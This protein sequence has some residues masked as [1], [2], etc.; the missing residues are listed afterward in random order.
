M[1]LSELLKK[2]GYIGNISDRNITDITCNSREAT[3][4]SVFVCIK[5]FVTDGHIYAQKAYECGCRA[6]VAEQKLEGIPEDADILYIDDA[7]RALALLSRTLYGDPS[8]ELTVIG[9]TGTKG[10]TTTALIIKQLLDASDVPTGYIGSNGVSY[11]KYKFD[12][13]NTTPESYKLQKY[14]REMLNA[15]MKAVVIEVSSQALALGRVLGIHFD[16]A[17]FTNLSSDHIGPHEH[18][19]FEEYFNA[20]KRLFDEYEPKT[21][22]ANADDPNTDAILT[23]CKAEIIYY[24]T[25]NI[26]DISAKKI[27]LYR[28]ES[29]LGTSFDCINGGNSVHCL[30]PIPGEFNVYNALA[31]LATVQALGISPTKASEALPNIKTEGRFEVIPSH[32]GACFIIDYAHNGLSLESVLRALR[33]YEPKRLICL[34]GSVGGRTQVRRA[35]LGHAA[36]L[37]ADL[38]ILTSDN[39]DFE[40]PQAIIDDIATQYESN[41]SYI[42]IPD[43]K[44]AIMYALEIAKSGDIVLLA[45]KGHEKYQRINGKNEY[46]CER[47]ILDDAIN[48]LTLPK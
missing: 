16:I 39:P 32:T 6:F 33:R 11:G 42:A 8:Q 30:L 26:A 5:G 18:N 12:T 40:D 2:T 38:S 15:G 10:K 34:F 46:F 20:K 41:A 9:I 44:E 47:E 24:S 48:L 4:S 36:A 45:G 14:M 25:K 35:Q 3:V 37:Y 21:V 17:I 7:R 13:S 29:T 31:A 28:S 19:S 23:D 43:R 1:L 22:I 27:A